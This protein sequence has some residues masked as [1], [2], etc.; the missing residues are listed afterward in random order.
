ML[1]QGGRPSTP[2][3]TRKSEVKESSIRYDDIGTKQPTTETER[4]STKDTAVVRRKSER[5]KN[6]SEV[7]KVDNT[8]ELPKLA[9][10][11]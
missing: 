5:T 6:Y 3:A 2:K 7:K 8:V 10:V 4:E 1:V 9:Q 11:I